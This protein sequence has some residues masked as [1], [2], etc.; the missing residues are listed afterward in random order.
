MNTV[1]EIL[2]RRRN[3]INITANPAQCAG[4]GKTEKAMVVSIAKNVEAY[5]YTFSRD[6]FDILLTYPKA[7]LESFYMDLMPKLKKLVGADREYHPMYPNFPRQVMGASDAELFINAIFH[8]FTFGNWLPEYEKDVR[9]PLFDNN[10]MTVLSVGHDDDIWDIFTAI[11]ES[12]TSISAQDKADVEEIIASNADFYNYLPD[13]IPLKENVALIAKII[14]KKA[15]IKNTSAIQKYFKTA[16][17][18]LRFITALS[19]GD[20]SLAAKTRYRSLRRCERRMVMNLLAGCGDILE[21]MY[22]Y[23]YR[24]I[25]IGEILH[26]SEFKRFRYNNVRDAFYV[27]RNKRKPLFI[28]GKIQ[29]A[30]NAHDVRTA[31]MLLKNRPGDFARQLDK[32]LRDTD[33]KDYVIDCFKN[34]VTSVSTPVLLQV[35]QHFM[36]RNSGNPVRVFFP[37]GNLAKSIVIKNDLPM[38]ENKICKTV[39]EI[40]EDAL[41]QNYKGRES[42][43][44]VYIDD[45][46]KNYLVPFS[47][48]SASSAGKTIIRGSII[49]IRKDAEAVRAFIWWT[50]NVDDRVDIDLSAAIYD[51]NWNFIDRVSYTQL[52]SGKMQAYH[53]GDIIDGGN[54]NGKG[55]AE[56]LDVT[57]DAVAKNGRY[58]VYQV[59]SFTRQKFS[60]LSNCRF[61]WMEREDVNSGEI[62]EPSTVE[63]SMVVGSESTVAIPVI[64]DCKE[65]KFVWC[66]MNLSNETCRSNHAGNNLENNLSGTTAA[67]YGM[68]HLNKANIYDLIMLNA[69]ARG[70]ITSDRSEADIIFSNDTR[71]PV[72][73]VE[74]EDE[75]TKEKKLIQRERKDV[76]IVTAFNVDYFMGQML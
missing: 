22:R 55:V 3:K 30:I 6:L 20:I 25:R 63:M 8:Y 74:I 53:S 42:L 69:K 71:V 68:T 15:A 75:A 5:G 32:L 44:S 2:L 37:K 14:A 35:R 41:I 51:K 17:D 40:C 61:G 34:V 62:F 64:F 7:D 21:D 1:N 54:V 39:V 23:R 49:P 60:E 50:N 16:T 66:D 57:I 65:R 72:E 12:K 45:E 52:R 33:D 29:A 36:N 19:D 28:T 47:Q 4:A 43:G 58:V 13:E 38:I 26:P 48:R 46:L 18:V 11:V 56:F 67:C 10:K 31:A 9:M 24:W 76:Q 59:F 73:V 70:K 27:L